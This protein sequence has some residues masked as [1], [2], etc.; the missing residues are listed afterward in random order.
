MKLGYLLVIIIVLLAIIVV[1]MVYPGIIIRDG[2]SVPL[3]PAKL[4]TSFTDID[5]ALASADND[6]AF[7]LFSKLND[8]EKLKRNVFVSPASIS[9]AL[10][11]TLNGASGKTAESMSKVLELENMQLEEINK[12]NANIMK[13]LE[14]G[15]PRVE[16]SIANSLWLSKDGDF[17]RDFL[18]RTV[19]A[20]QAE[21]DTLDFTSPGASPRVNRWANKATR[22]Y[23][24]DI[25]A[26][27][28]FDDATAML[29]VNAIYFNGKWTKPFKPEA[30]S[31]MPFH[32][33]DRSE[34]QVRMMNESDKYHYMENV[35]FQAINLPYGDKRFSMYVFLPSKESSLEE[36]CKSLDS[37]NWNKWVSEMKEREGSIRL[38]RFKMEFDIRL[39]QILSQMGMADAFQQTADFTGMSDMKPLYIGRVMHKT[40]LEVDEQGTK[41]AAVTHV[42][43]EAAI[44]TIAGDPPFVMIVDR[45][46]FCAIVDNQSSLILFMGAITNP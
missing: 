39:D 30:T 28:S 25:V 5:P 37:T 12:G 41:A 10:T 44:V 15:D 17:K 11:M 29:L 7:K 2:R 18:S 38:P 35:K 27:S 21:V 45:P 19:K 16:M 43:M 32:L 20:Y 24:R 36:F 31:D 46:F 9:L 22:G 40:F 3:N 4:F 42:M 23:I 26:P 8:D 6:F 13:S 14:N 33:P 1:L 34:K